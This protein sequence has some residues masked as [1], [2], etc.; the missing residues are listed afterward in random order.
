MCLCEGCPSPFSSNIGSFQN[1]RSVFNPSPTHLLA[2]TLST[3]SHTHK[4]KQTKE[5]VCQLSQ[6]RCWN[7]SCNS[8]VR[9]WASEAQREKGGW[10]WGWRGVRVDRGPRL[11]HSRSWAGEKHATQTPVLLAAA[12]LA[13]WK[14][15]VATNPKI[16][17][18][19]PPSTIM[20]PAHSIFTGL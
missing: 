18:P 6:Y 19:L 14:S 11:T 13:M 16:L 10:E 3:P 9:T 12:F 7:Q 17:P 20:P 2:N 5:K 1:K 4:Y 15:D 8:E